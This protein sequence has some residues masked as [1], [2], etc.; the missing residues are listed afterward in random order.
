MQ[1]VEERNS[2]IEDTIW[3]IDQSNEMLNLKK[4]LT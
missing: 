3:E 2:D 4:I 1:E